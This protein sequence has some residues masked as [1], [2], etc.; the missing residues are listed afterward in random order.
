MQKITI[1]VKPQ[2]AKKVLQILEALQPSLVEKINLQNEIKPVKSSLNKTNSN[3]RYLSKEAYKQKLQKQP[4]ME[5]EFL[6]GK[7]SSGKYASTQEY[8]KRLQK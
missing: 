4:V 3:S 2:N 6:A 7:S 5:D 1:D 8:K